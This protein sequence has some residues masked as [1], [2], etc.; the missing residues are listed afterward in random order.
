MK[1][2]FRLVA[3]LAVF[4]ALAGFLLAWV[5]VKT[6]EPIE[7]AQKAEMMQSFKKILPAY[8]NDIISDAVKT[9]IAGSEW[10]FFVG[11][12]EGEV[13]GVAFIS[14]SL[15]GYGGK[16][17]MAC[18]ISAQEKEIYGVD[19]LQANET[20]GLGSKLKEQK[21]LSQFPGKKASD[22]EWA[23]VEKDNGEIDAITGATISSRAAAEAIK[24]GLDALIKC[25]DSIIA[26]SGIQK[27]MEK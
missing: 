6:K 26:D 21:F 13:T 20:P 10:T 19:V 8:D 17:V 18:G 3:T 12:K 7:A 16:I 2:T 4:C 23:R 14:E 5:N 15:R 24:S 11:K 27:G 25:M 22:S 9:N 1:E